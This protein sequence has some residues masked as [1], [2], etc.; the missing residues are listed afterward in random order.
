MHSSARISFNFLEINTIDEASIP[1][2]PPGGCPQGTFDSLNT[3]YCEDHCS[4]ET[5]WLINPPLN[6][7]SNIANESVWAWNAQKNVWVAQSKYQS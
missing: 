4:W 7:L 2:P 5:C 3:C 6:C 1:K